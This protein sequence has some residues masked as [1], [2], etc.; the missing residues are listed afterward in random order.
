[1]GKTVAGSEAEK[2][3]GKKSLEYAKL[4]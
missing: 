3:S 4:E 2:S 1:M